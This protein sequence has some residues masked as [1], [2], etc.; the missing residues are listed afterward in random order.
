MPSKNGGVSRSEETSSIVHRFIH[1]AE[2]FKRHPSFCHIFR[3][4]LQSI[5]SAL[6]KVAHGASVDRSAVFK[7]NSSAI[8]RLCFSWFHNHIF[9]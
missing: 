8:D 1:L 4:Q 9:C 7:R 3:K 2:Q 6:G 5:E